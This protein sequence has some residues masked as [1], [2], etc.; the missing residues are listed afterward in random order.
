MV[1]NP[2]ILGASADGLLSGSVSTT[3][4]IA[5]DCVALQ[6]DGFVAVGTSGVALGSEWTLS[7]WVNDIASAGFRTLF[8]GFTGDHQVH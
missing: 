7:V 8:R 2:A 3:S 4:G 5:G 6:S 1:T